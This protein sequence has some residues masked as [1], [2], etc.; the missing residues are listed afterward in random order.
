[1]DFIHT[2]FGYQ[3]FITREFLPA[4]EFGPSLTQPA[5]AASL[6]VNQTSIG[7]G[8]VSTEEQQ[9]P[10]SAVRSFDTSAVGVVVHGVGAI[11]RIPELL[12]QRGGRR[13]VLLGSR[14][15]VEDDE[16][17]ERLRAVLGDR[18]IGVAPPIG[19]HTPPADV[20]AV[21]QFV[22]DVGG[23]ALVAVGGSSVSDGAKLVALR[24]GGGTPAVVVEDGVVTRAEQGMVERP[25]PLIVVPTTLSAGEH[26]GSAGMVDGRRGVKVMVEDPRLLPAGIVLDPELV[27]STPTQLW[28]T[29]GLKAMDHAAETIWGSR[30]HPVGDAV[31]ADALRRLSRSLPRTLQV[32]D[33][34]EARLDC[35]LAAWMSILTM[36]NTLI[37]LSHPLEHNMGARWH[38]DHGVT[39]CIALPVVMDYLADETPAKVARVARALDP[40][41]SRAGSDLRV[42]KAGAVWLAG[43]VRDLGVPSRLRDVLPSLAG[44]DDVA[45][46]SAVT[47]EYFGYVPAGG[48]TT[49]KELIVRMW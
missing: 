34:L 22:R 21:E 7:D 19:A 8:R 16:L 3:E 45:R 5:T 2:V 39:S 25:I 28:V 10:D 48:E 38:L 14:S 1:V 18:L 4:L 20:D 27:L 15:V 35:M 47:L 17:V 43:F 6:P 49:L 36:T 42:A 30:S 37:H 26:R 23:D 40:G 46:Q 33:D 29:T 41:G 12:D 9:M 24:A 32:P 11:G 31:A 13:V 44:I